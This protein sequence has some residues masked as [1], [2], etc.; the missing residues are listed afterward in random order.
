[1]SSLASLF[2]HSFFTHTRSL[3]QVFT[4][5]VCCPFSRKSSKSSSKKAFSRCVCALITNS[6]C[7]S[8]WIGFTFLFFL[9]HFTLALR[10]QALFST[11]TF[12][13]GLNMPAKTVVFTSVRKFDGD[14]FRVVTSGEYIQ[15][16]GRAGRRGLDDRGIVILMLD[17]KMDPPTAKGM[18]K[19]AADCLNS[20]FHLGYNMLLNLIRVEEADPQYMIARSF[21]QFQALSA[22][23]QMQQQL[24]AWRAAHDAIALDDEKQ[25]C[26]TFIIFDCISA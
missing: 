10:A 26:Q 14:D 12:S 3:I 4:T 2:L 9:L 17:E 6:L 24:T 5:V 1:M 20:S 18:L 16:S 7:F 13:M 11:E 19:G 22:A 23:P 8:L 15:M 21:H 25:V